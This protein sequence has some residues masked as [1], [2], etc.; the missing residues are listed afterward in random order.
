MALSE[1][2]VEAVDGG[3]NILPPSSARALVI[4]GV[5]PKGTPGTLFAFGRSSAIL[6]GLDGGPLAEAAAYCLLGGGSIRALVVEPNVAGD[7]SAVTKEGVGAAEMT[8][9][10]GPH[11]TITIEI[12]TA[13]AI[14][15]M[16]FKWKVGNGAFSAPVLSSADPFRVPGTFTYLTFAAGTY[17][18]GSSYVIGTD[19][20]ITRSS[21]VATGGSVT[22]DSATVDLVAGQHTDVSIDQGAA[23]VW[24]WGG[25]Y[26]NCKMAAA[27]AYSG[28]VG[29]TF[30]V[31]WVDEDGAHETV[32]TVPG[33][34]AA[35]ELALIA[36]LNELLLTS[37]VPVLVEDSGDSNKLRFITTRL[38]TSADVSITAVTGAGF[39]AETGIDV[40][41]A[42]AAGTATCAK[43]GGTGTKTVTIAFLDAATP[44]EIVAAIAAADGLTG[45]TWSAPTS[46]TQRIISSTTGASP[47]GVQ[48][49]SASTNSLGFDNAEHNGGASTI[50]ID[51]VT[52]ASS[53]VD[54]FDVLVRVTKSGAL[55][56][57][58]V[59]ISLDGGTDDGGTEGADV[60]PSDAGLYVI[61]GTGLA[62]T[63]DDD[64]VEGDKYSFVAAP[65]TGDAEAV[66]AALATLRAAYTSIAWRL[67]WV[68]GG[69][70]SASDA[71]AGFATV[72]SEMESFE[73]VFKYGRAFV[74]CPTVGS[75][76]VTGGAAARDT[77]DD[78]T[79]VLTALSALVS[80]D[81]RTGIIA[82]EARTV[83]AYTHKRRPYRCDSWAIMRRLS[84]IRAGEDG[85]WVG[86]GALPGITKLRRDEA[87]SPVLTE[88]G[89]N[90]LRSY[91]GLGGYYVAGT[92]GGPGVRA[93]TANTSDFYRTANG[94]VLDEA[95]A[96]ARARGLILIQQSFRVDSAT[97][98]ILDRDALALESQ[99]TQAVQAE[100]TQPS[101]ADAS[102]AAVTV[103]RNT[104]ILETGAL[105]FDVAVVPLGY[106]S[107]VRGRV[108]LTTT[109][110]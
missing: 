14:A 27:G 110:T 56:V 93:K 83:S 87:A 26:G 29:G 103:D 28:G 54:A 59:R 24:T 99:L 85:A 2:R 98:Q 64:L 37:G 13:G 21:G 88:A 17:V 52:Q 30:T 104:N 7:V 100:L 109:L 58:Q 4:A 63:F 41:A 62:V 10:V 70:A 47:K 39:T 16:R 105:D 102:D 76:I 66:G 49:K 60:T 75:I 57:G 3:L 106:A 79:A 94:R 45:G 44:A 101:P 1:A 84:S 19:G 107:A 42:T 97:G 74:E 46:T 32:I 33:T 77:A 23:Q 53:A 78:D 48:V 67:L 91:E 68:M 89:I 55:G 80:T 20:T 65:P 92:E 40:T 50:A 86:R 18:L 72:D 73:A 96:I 43:T 5:S 12:E 81:G 15:T 61:P 51:T 38:G 90:T 9:A 35:G 82:G 11:R 36:K 69:A 22:S 6:A 34:V 8:V 108:G 31:R 71:A 95:M 25:T